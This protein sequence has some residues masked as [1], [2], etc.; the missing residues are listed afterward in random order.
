M[1]AITDSSYKS[2]CPRCEA[3]AD[4]TTIRVFGYGRQIIV[5]SIHCEV[6][7]YGLTPAALEAH[8]QTALS[9]H[10]PQGDTDSA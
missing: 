4:A 3:R 5:M 2:R 8:A 10:A 6:C 9:A 1:D 7:G